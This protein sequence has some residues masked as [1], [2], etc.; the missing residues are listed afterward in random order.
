[1]FMPPVLD[2]EQVLGV[3]HLRN[4]QHRRHSHYPDLRKSA[5]RAFFV[6]I[7]RSTCGTGSKVFS[8]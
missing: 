4:L 1:M 6:I 3:R 5:I 8:V 2:C 7:K